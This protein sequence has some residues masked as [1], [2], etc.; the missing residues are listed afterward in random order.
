M[1]HKNRYNPKALS[2]FVAQ[3]N[4]FQF[5]FVYTNDETEKMVDEGYGPPG[6]GV[7]LVCP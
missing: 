5:K 3:A 2:E 7:W 1:H 6:E 4:A